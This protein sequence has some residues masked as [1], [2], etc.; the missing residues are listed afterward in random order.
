MFSLYPVICASDVALSRDYYRD[1]LGMKVVF[2]SGW[3]VHLQDPAN[4]TVQL[5]IVARE[6]DTV[7]VGYRTEPSGVLV[8]VEV[9][10]TDAIHTRAVE[11]G[12]T[13]V[14]PLRSEEFGQ[15]HFMTV[16]P[17]GL[18]VDVVTVIP[19]SEEQA[20]FSV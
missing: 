16:D 1:V 19:F 7:P 5:G 13:I 8:T 15:R 10:D 18:L 2:D 17:D 9:D 11:H 20:A 14:M 3:F 4:E 6:H 12:L